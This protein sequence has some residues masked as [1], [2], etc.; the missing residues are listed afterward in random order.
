MTAVESYK[1]F[2][3]AAKGLARRFDI[4]GCQLRLL[5]SDNSKMIS[6]NIVRH[7]ED[8][9]SVEDVPHV[10]RRFHGCVDYLQAGVSWSVITSELSRCF[11]L[12]T[13]R[14]GKAAIF[15]TKEDQEEKLT[16]WYTKWKRADVFRKNPAPQS[17]IEVVYKSQMA[18]VRAGK[19]THDCERLVWHE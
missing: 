3:D 11:Y 13:A 4:L 12:S 9:R 6:D 19:C 8:C 5:G 16:A 15:H 14:D 10:L 2:E 18:M 7:F 17:D 1:T